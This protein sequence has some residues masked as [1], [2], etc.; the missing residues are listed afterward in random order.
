M[1]TNHLVSSVG[2]QTHDLSCNDDTKAPT[3]IAWINDT[4]VF[5][6]IAWINDNSVFLE[7]ANCVN[8]DF[9]KNKVFELRKNFFELKNILAQ[10]YQVHKMVESVESSKSFNP[11]LNLFGNLFWLVNLGKMCCCCC[12]HAHLG[13]TFRRSSCR[14]NKPAFDSHPL[15][16][17]TWLKRLKSYSRYPIAIKYRSCQLS[18]KRFTFSS[19]HLVIVKTNCFVL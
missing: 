7:I 9:H 14:I 19:N 2:I 8:N 15:Y 12:H 3:Q 4:S 16:I 11:G 17:S 6:E 5:M 18:S 1:K 10:N 13:T